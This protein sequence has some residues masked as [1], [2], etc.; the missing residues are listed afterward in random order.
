MTRLRVGRE[1][2]LSKDVV[3][4]PPSE[5]ST[6]IS[7]GLVESE[8]VREVVVD[9]SEA[10]QHFAETAPNTP[11]AGEEASLRKPFAESSLDLDESL[12]EVGA[13]CNVMINMY[14]IKTLFA[15]QFLPIL[16]DI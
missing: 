8:I 1:A 14:C 11:A 3:L 4:P 6:A 7:C 16:L 13:L 10:A 5:R 2:G 12:S 9:L 15:L